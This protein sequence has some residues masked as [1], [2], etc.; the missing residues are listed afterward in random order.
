MISRDKN[1]STFEELH[2]KDADAVVIIVTS[3]NDDKILLNKEFRMA[4]GEWVY[5]LPCRTY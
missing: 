5:N 3:E 1:I 2:G 4:T